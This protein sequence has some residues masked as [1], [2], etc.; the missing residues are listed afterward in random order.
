MRDYPPGGPPSYHD[1]HVTAPGIPRTRL[2]DLPYGL[3]VGLQVQC[4]RTAGWQLWRTAA[5][6]RD[7]ELI[8]GEYDRHQHGPDC[9]VGC[10]IPDR[11]LVLDVRGTVIVDSSPDRVSLASNPALSWE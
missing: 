1:L 4:D 6:L 7:W 8:G 3:Q 10:A 2:F 5:D 11:W 9:V